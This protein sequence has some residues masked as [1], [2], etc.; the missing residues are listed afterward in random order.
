MSKR[1]VSDRERSVN[2]YEQGV[3]GAGVPGIPGKA[4]K[5]EMSERKGVM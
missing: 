5:E 3:C 1:K 2:V 4:G